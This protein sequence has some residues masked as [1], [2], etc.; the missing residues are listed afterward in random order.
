MRNLAAGF[1]YP[2][3]AGGNGLLVVPNGTA[4]TAFVLSSIP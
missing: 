4:L 3:V 2:G 1:W